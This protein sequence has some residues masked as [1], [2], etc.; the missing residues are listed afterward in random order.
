[1]SQNEQEDFD[2]EYEQL[3]ATLCDYISNMESD[4]IT[5]RDLRVIN[6]LIDFYGFEA[7][8]DEIQYIL[9]DVM[10]YYD[11]TQKEKNDGLH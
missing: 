7:D 8:P 11:R 2:Q 10:E 4:Q 6:G 5:E 3:L 9:D 1:M